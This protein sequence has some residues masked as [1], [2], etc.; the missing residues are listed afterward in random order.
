VLEVKL[1]AVVEATTNN[2][3]ISVCNMNER[4]A[5]KTFVL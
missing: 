1:V 5:R 2:V 4:R 3:F